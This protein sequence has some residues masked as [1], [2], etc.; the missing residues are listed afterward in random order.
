[1]FSSKNVFLAY[2]AEYHTEFNSPFDDDVE[3]HIQQDFPWSS[4]F[5]ESTGNF[6]NAVTHES[7]VDAASSL[8]DLPILNASQSLE[9]VL[10]KMFTS[11]Q[12]QPD[13]LNE[14]I[15]KI[16]LRPMAILKSPDALVSADSKQQICNVL[17]SL[18]DM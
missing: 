7:V 18:S 16:L 13:R 11:E 17:I 8:G 1:M 3:N 4:A 5:C 15:G 9:L 12:F 2:F 10:R 14:L 6:Q